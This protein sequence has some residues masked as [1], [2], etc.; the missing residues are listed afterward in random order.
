MIYILFVHYHS[1]HSPSR[2]LIVWIISSFAASRLTCLLQLI[3]LSVAADVD[4]VSFS[5]SAV[6][7]HKCVEAKP[8]VG[9]GAGADVKADIRVPTNMHDELGMKRNTSTQAVTISCRCHTAIASK[10]TSPREKKASAS[11]PVHGH[12]HVLCGADSS[13]CTC[14]LMMS[15]R[16]CEICISICMCMC[17]CDWF[18]S[19]SAS[20]SL[21]IHRCRCQCSVDELEQYDVFLTRAGAS[22][23]EAVSASSMSSHITVIYHLTHQLYNYFEA[24]RLCDDD[25]ELQ[26]A[27]NNTI[28]ELEQITG[29]TMTTTTADRNKQQTDTTMDAVVHGDAHQHT[30]MRVDISSASLLQ[31]VQKHGLISLDV[32][33]FS[34]FVCTV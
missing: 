17:M 3:P 6:D 14:A 5:Q 28:K 23:L 24:L 26:V 32:K 33:P 21:P 22:A 25:V 11:A 9:A 34:F 27:I 18:V 10:F 15:A 20:L 2:V 31:T 16:V 12:V 30:L 19:V 29:T 7:K 4:V 13:P 1:I 8:D